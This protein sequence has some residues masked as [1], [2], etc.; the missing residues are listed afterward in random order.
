MAKEINADLGKLSLRISVGG[1]MIFHGI[2]KLIH[3]HDFIKEILA[4]KGLPQFLWIGVPTGEV[5]A[6]I[7]LLLGVFTRIS[8]L[9]IVFTMLMTF[10]LIHGINDF[11]L[12][13]TG[14]VKVELNLLYLF[15]S[16][17]IFF[18][19]SGKYSLYKGNK[20]ILI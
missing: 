16:L 19:G 5:I 7:C 14:G 6:P 2:A 15:S 1:L 20:G 12:S 18:L 11:S 17:A 3:G 10:Y 4:S 9:L 13:Q 8:S